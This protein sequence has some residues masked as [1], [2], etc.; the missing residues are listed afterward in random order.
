[1]RLAIHS[2]LLVNNAYFLPTHSIKE[3]KKEGG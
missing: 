3:P 1:M 2:N